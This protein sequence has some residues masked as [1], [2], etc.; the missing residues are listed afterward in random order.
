MVSLI[1]LVLS[2]IH[3]LF[4]ALKET[5]CHVSYPMKKPRWQRTE[6]DYRLSLSL[7][8]FKILKNIIQLKLYWLRRNLDYLFKMY[9]YHNLRVST[10]VGRMVVPLK[11][12][13]V[14]ILET[15]EWSYLEK[16]TQVLIPCK[17]GWA[18]IKAYNLLD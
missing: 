17:K 3:A 4:L 14:L 16:I 7:V 9:Q 13:H 10:V 1:L 15:C 11:Y 12:V 2:W 5:C 8:F 18:D 6:D